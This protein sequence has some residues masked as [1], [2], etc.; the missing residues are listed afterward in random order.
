MLGRQPP[1]PAS[2]LWGWLHDVPGPWVRGAAHE[3]GGY[4][5]L[6]LLQLPLYLVVVVKGS[7]KAMRANRVELDPIFS[8]DIIIQIRLH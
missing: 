3:N 5:P 7:S 8:Q 1:Q 2:K 4:A 6:V